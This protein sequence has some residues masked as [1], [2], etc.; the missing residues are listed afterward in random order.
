MESGY[1]Y[2][3][4]KDDDLKSFCKDNNIKKTSNIFICCKDNNKEQ[5]FNCIKSN[6]TDYDED[7]HYCH[8][9]NN[10]LYYIDLNQAYKIDMELEKFLNIKHGILEKKCMIKYNQIKNNYNTIIEKKYIE[11]KY[12][13]N[14]IKVT[15]DLQVTNYIKNSN[16]FIGK[17]NEYLVI[18][19]K[20][21]NYLINKIL[22][23]KNENNIPIYMDN[24]VYG[25]INLNF[26]YIISQKNFVETSNT[27]FNVLDYYKKV[28]K[29]KEEYLLNSKKA[30]STKMKNIK[31]NIDVIIRKRN[32]TCN[33]MG[34]EVLECLG[35]INLVNRNGNLFMMETNIFYCKK[36]QKYYMNELEYE[37]LRK[38]GSPVCKIITEE[39]YSQISNGFYEMKPESELHSMG[40]NVNKLDNLSDTQ[41]K[42]ILATIIDLN[43]L[44]KSEVDS[45]LSYLIRRSENINKYRDAVAKW[46][47]DREYI[48]NYKKSF[49]STYNIATIIKKSYK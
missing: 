18:G 45:H 26:T 5:Y 10:V 20:D 22:N 12:I 21:N 27:K 47:K 43:L 31:R 13:G 8:K 39:V 24:S 6:L 29:L 36:C 19:E 37:Q 46:K 34:H 25:Y 4:K 30:I 28:L 48:L 15:N 49:A 3:F 1:F 44:K 42:K 41:R 7:F 2:F 16:C 11:K 9:I 40:Y 14:I 38:F 32:N 23:R 17:N 35:K 33:K